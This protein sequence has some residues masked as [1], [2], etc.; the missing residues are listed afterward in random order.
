MSLEGLR[1]EGG[2]AILDYPTALQAN[3]AVCENVGV[4][5]NSTLAQYHGPLPP[6]EPNSRDP[7]TQM[8]NQDKFNSIQ[9][10]LQNYERITKELWGQIETLRGAL[11]Q[12][13]HKQDGGVVVP[14]R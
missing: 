3:Q 12:H 9:S 11:R 8:C 6:D 14:Y 13:Q 2:Y 7:W 4:Q 1:P 5:S 10:R